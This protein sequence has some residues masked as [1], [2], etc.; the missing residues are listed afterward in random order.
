M[1]VGNR[2]N[3]SYFTYTDDNAV[4][5]NV[6]GEDGGAGTA[7]DG[8]AAFTAGAPVWGRNSRVRHVRYVE[9]TDPATFRKVRFIVYTPTAFAAI[10]GGD[11][12]AVTAPGSATTINYA[13]SAKVPERQPIAGASRHL[14]D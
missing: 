13:V 3:K 5:W 6:L 8:H 10:S 11:T 9:A 14:L 7:V 4:D 1:A 2:K 12:I